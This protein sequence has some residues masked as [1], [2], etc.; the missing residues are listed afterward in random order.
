MG[1]RIPGDW[2]LC[3]H[4]VLAK[5]CHKC[6]DERIA[7]QLGIIANLQRDLAQRTDEYEAKV[8]ECI[9]LEKKAGVMREALE[10]QSDLYEKALTAGGGSCAPETVRKIV[11][12]YV[13]R[14][15]ALEAAL[16]KI[17]NHQTQL[18]WGECARIAR[19]ARNPPTERMK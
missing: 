2:V 8:D 13:E 19:A 15:E 17:E 9:D 3:W 7:A 16:R 6:K 12:P 1:Q 18:P 10:K 14:I 11:Q 5:D 4:D